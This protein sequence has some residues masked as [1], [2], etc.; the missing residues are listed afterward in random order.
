MIRGIKLRMNLLS[1]VDFYNDQISF[2]KSNS[3]KF[4]Q[5]ITKNVFN[6]LITLQL[7]F[8]KGQIIRNAMIDVF[9]IYTF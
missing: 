8:D 4:I 9:H 1:K 7:N 3:F 2:V 5:I 6:V